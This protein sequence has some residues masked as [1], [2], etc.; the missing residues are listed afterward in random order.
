MSG[1]TMKGSAVL[2]SVL[3]TIS[4]YNMLAPGCRLAVAVSGGADSVCLLHAIRELAPQIGVTLAG[5]AHLN[6]Q[7]RGEASDEDERF[8]ASLT[9]RL[10]LPFYRA[11]A[12]LT[13]EPGNLGRNLEQAARRA[14]SEFFAGLIR[15]GAADR[16][17]LGHTRDDQAETV[18]FRI[19]RG[20]G[21]SGL[22][23]ISPVTRER[24]HPAADRGHPRGSGGVSMLPRNPLARGRDQPGASIYAQPHP[25]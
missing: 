8:V 6:H 17:A 12:R 19:L 4:R 9:G 16:V 11:S 13:G 7:L 25:A 1:L 2:E 22:A 23:G 24:I 3:K 21:L 14:R 15:D 5:V 18:L 20:S 10:D